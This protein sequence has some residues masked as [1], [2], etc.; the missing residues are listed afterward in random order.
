M[1]AIV[2]DAII[3]VLLICGMVYA[4]LV[5]LRV[6]RLTNL[7]RELEPAVQQFSVAVDKSEASVIQM[8]RNILLGQNAETDDTRHE[9]VEAS[10]R[11]S[12][13][14][15]VSEVRDVGMRVVR[16]KQEMVRRFFDLSRSEGR[17]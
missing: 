17:T 3:V 5:N 4:G 12:S 15:N 7:L 2:I 10:P 11:F 14:R 6:K 9:K 13:R 8:Q 1:A 16:N